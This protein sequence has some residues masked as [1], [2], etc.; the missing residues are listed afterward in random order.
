MFVTFSKAFWNAVGAPGGIMEI[1]GF[2]YV[3]HL[4]LCDKWENDAVKVRFGK[5]ARSEW[6]SASVISTPGDHVNAFTCTCF[7]LSHAYNT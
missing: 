2:M 1:T 3:Y 7:T 6:R 5:N 4:S